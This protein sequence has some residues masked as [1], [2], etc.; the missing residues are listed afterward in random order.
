MH[1]PIHPIASSIVCDDD[2][3][4]SLHP[5]VHLQSQICWILPLWIPTN[6]LPPM[7][8]LEFLT[9]FSSN[10]SAPKQINSCPAVE[11]RLCKR[12]KNQ[13][14]SE[15]WNIQLLSRFQGF[16]WL[17]TQKFSWNPHKWMKTLLVNFFECGQQHSQN[18]NFL[19]HFFDYV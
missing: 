18:V 5:V 2:N 1:I 17:V 4:L 14:L 19:Q 16:H 12:K 9:C 15:G 3:W 6:H 8:V 11:K 7:E 13:P 10:T